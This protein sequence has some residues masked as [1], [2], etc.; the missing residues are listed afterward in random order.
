MNARI[1]TGECRHAVPLPDVYPAPHAIRVYQTV[2]ILASCV[3]SIY[4]LLVLNIGMHTNSGF[5]QQGNAVGLDLSRVTKLMGSYYTTH[6]TQN[7]FYKLF[8]RKKKIFEVVGDTT[9]LMRSLKEDPS[10]RIPKQTSS[11]TLGI[12]WT[13]L[14]PR[15]SKPR[16]NKK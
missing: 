13:G 11:R 7:K 12:L 15:Y 3:E 14:G 6:S 4:A 1:L 8:K 5:N 10:D 16:T 2:S 9:T